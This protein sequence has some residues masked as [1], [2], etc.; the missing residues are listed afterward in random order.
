MPSAD[1]LSEYHLADPAAT[2]VPPCGGGGGV[3]VRE[4]SPPSVLSTMPLSKPLNG[5]GLYDACYHGEIERVKAH[6]ALGGDLNLRAG[7]LYGNSTGLMGAAGGGQRDV[8]EWLVRA[9][10]IEIDAQNGS[11]STALHFAANNGKADCVLV[12]LEGGAS[13]LLKDKEGRTAL[14]VAREWN[15]SEVVAVMQQHAAAPPAPQPALQPQPAPQPQDPEQ[16]FVALTGT[17]AATARRFLRQA[18]G[19]LARA[20]D[21]FFSAAPPQLPEGEPP[22][23]EPEPE[24]LLALPPIPPSP[25]SGG[26]FRGTKFHGVYPKAKAPADLFKLGGKLTTVVRGY[27][28]AHGIPYDDDEGEAYVDQLQADMVGAGDSMAQ[29]VQRMWTS[30]RQLRG[31]EFCFILN[32]VVR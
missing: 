28:E 18:G 21:A 5:Y 9:P 13:A 24:P 8:V 11:G 29:A 32:E 17:D 27:C 22:E 15:R 20:V 3:S 30:F 12:L 23:P 25:V 2:E 14:K 1:N 7:A 31:R 16:T 26:T 6:G 10:G 4:H 19:D